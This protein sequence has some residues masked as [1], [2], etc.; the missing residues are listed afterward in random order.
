MSRKEAIIR[1]HLIIRKLRRKPSTL[2]E[3]EDF[4]ARESEL[5]EFDFTISARTFKRDL[6]EIRLIYNID[7][8]Y[9]FSR[10]VYYIQD[11][12]DSELS[13]RLLEAFDMVNALSLT[14]RVSQHIHF[15]K[16]RPQG[17]E[18]LHGLLHAIKNQLQIHFDYHIYWNDTVT[19][20]D[21]EPY[22]LKEFRNRWYV[23]GVDL[24]DGQVKSFALDRLSGLE[25]TKVR[26]KKSMSFDV[27]E[28]YK[29]CY[30]IISPNGD[31]PEEVLLWFDRHQ[32]KYIQ[33]LPLHES[34]EVVSDDETG[35]VVRLKLFLTHDFIMEILSHGSHVKVLAPGYLKESIEAELAQTL[36]N[37]KTKID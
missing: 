11:D 22:A 19:Q 21:V 24:K 5:Q 37:Y 33:S 23:L 6:D 2:K 26:F 28:H 4:L 8:D 12:G 30:G 13:G 32:G 14:D 1:Y 29:N 3:I 18:N 15:E 10:R 9:D 31:L 17:T 20:R 16:R 34:Q 36:N 35:L 25:I 7:I 27:N